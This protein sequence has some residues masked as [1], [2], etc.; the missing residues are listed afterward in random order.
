MNM[1]IVPSGTPTYFYAI[2]YFALRVHININHIIVN[3]RSYYIA[4]FENNTTGTGYIQ[5]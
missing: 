3:T 1:N 2:E 5:Q 4:N